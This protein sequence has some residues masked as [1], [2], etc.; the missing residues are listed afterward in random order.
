MTEIRRIDTIALKNGLQLELFDESRPMAGDRWLVCIAARVAVDIQT[1]A[2]ELS[3]QGIDPEA[4]ARRIGPETI[5]EHRAER[6]FVDEK[7]RGA[8]LLSE[9]GALL[10]TIAGY[11]AKPSFAN[12]LVLKRYREAEEKA[13]WYSDETA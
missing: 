3:R 10:D 4:V 5:Y 8:V 11:I 1:V 9:K 12:R 7:D 6:R 2:E 13:K